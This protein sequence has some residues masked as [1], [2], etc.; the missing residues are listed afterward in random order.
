MGVNLY[1]KKVRRNR[2][3]GKWFLSRSKVNDL[4]YILYNGI[5]K[6]KI[7]QARDLGVKMHISLQEDKIK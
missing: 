7:S 2:G 6:I 1:Q 4:F 5:S 3:W